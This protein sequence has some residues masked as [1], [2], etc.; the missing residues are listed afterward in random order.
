MLA[1]FVWLNASIALGLVSAKCGISVTQGHVGG[2]LRQPYIK[3]LGR[4]ALLATVTPILLTSLPW[5]A[6]PRCAW[7]KP[8]LSIVLCARPMESGCVLLRSWLAYRFCRSHRGTAA[9]H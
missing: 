3:G 4:R 6:A 7:P 9:V 1:F 2:F 5:F 8:A